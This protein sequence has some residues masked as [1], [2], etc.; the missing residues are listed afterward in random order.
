MFCLLFCLG[1]QAEF[2][3]RISIVVE[4]ENWLRL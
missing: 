2:E 1:L 4:G 3:A